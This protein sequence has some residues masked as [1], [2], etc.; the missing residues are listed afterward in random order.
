MTVEV[1]ELAGPHAADRD[2]GRRRP[3][4][5]SPTRCCSTATSTSSRRWTGW[6]E[7]LGPW[8]PVIEGDR[9]YG[10]GGADDGYAA[11]AS[12]L[13]IEAGPAPRRAPCPLRRADR[14]Q[15]G[16]RQPRPPAHLERSAGGS[17]SPSLVVCLDSACIDYDRLWVT[18]SLRGLVGRRARASTSSTRASTPGWP[19][20]V[21]AVELPHRPPAA[22]PRSRTSTPA[23][24]LVPEMHVEIPTDRIDE[25]GKT[26]AELPEPVADHFPFV[27]GAEPVVHDPAEQLLAR[28]WRPDAVGD[29][30]RRLGRRRPGPA[31]CCGRTPRCG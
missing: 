28:T 9:L 16:E 24:V 8:T 13:A 29:R 4:R 30:R 14:G 3:I 6:R 27:D 31:T 12:L 17:A 23:S 18:T 5:R 15:R 19:S 26:A 11:F 7:G 20:G 25:A 21:V 2:G 22:R 10:R 1:Q